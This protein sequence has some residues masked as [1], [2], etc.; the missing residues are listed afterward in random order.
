VYY[1]VVVPCLFIFEFLC[2]STVTDSL[3]LVGNN[4]DIT[5]LGTVHVCVEVRKEILAKLRHPSTLISFY[6]AQTGGTANNKLAVNR[7]KAKQIVNKREGT[8]F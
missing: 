4:Q 1:S 8:A 5:K 2:E 7:I 3:P 6:V